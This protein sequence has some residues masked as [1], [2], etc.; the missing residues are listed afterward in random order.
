MLRGF[1]VSVGALLVLALLFVWFALPPI[2]G[3]V[4]V[5]ILRDAGVRSQDLRVEV[6]ADPPL[7]L[8]GLEADRV[9]VRAS[10]VEIETLRADVMDVTLREVSL[11]ERTFEVVE[12]RLEGA[13]LTPATGPTVRVSSVQLSGPPERALMTMVLSEDDVASLVRSTV[14]RSL[15]V[16]ATDVSLEAPDRMSFRI[17][18]ERVAG[19]LTIRPDGTLAFIEDRGQITL[20]LFRSSPSDPAVLRSLRVDGDRLEVTGTL[21]LLAPR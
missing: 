13:S 11:R 8:I 21:D 9:R 7:R 3:G 14:A 2:L 19:R 6:A 16:E 10:D 18:Q 1:V 15:G 20:D 17:G 5:G 4:A 12:G